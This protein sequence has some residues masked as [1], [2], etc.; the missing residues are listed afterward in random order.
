MVPSANLDFDKKVNNQEE[1][2]F[3]QYTQS[4]LV[5]EVLSATSLLKG[6]HQELIN[7][8]EQYVLYD[9]IESNDLKNYVMNLENFGI[10][11]IAKFKSIVT[12]EEYALISLDG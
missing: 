10:C 4:P 2:R 12:F 7:N 5:Q 8:Y 3:L 11:K 1:L 6:K 9:E